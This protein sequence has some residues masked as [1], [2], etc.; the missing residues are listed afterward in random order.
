[1][2][3]AEI[4]MMQK[5]ADVLE[6]RDRE[7]HERKRSRLAPEQPNGSDSHQKLLSKFKAND[8]EVRVRPESPMEEYVVTGDDMGIHKGAPEA[9]RQELECAFHLEGMPEFDVRDLQ[10]IS[11]VQLS[12]MCL[13]EQSFLCT[14][15]RKTLTRTSFGTFC[16]QKN[17]L[18]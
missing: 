17:E 6:R 16:T 10:S 8:K 9:T 7:E 1:M 14:V 2:K 13:Q 3:N 4:R 12:E 15:K 5:F 18:G 11:G